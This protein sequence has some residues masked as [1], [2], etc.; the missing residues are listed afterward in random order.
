MMIVT[1]FNHPG[2]II[3]GVRLNESEDNTELYEK[4]NSLAKKLDPSRATTG[5]RFFSGSELKEDIYAI[6]DFCHKGP[7][8]EAV[9][10]N[11]R[12]VTGLN[13][14]VPYIVS[15]FCGHVFPCK[16]WDNENIRE[17]HA[18]MHAR[19][20]S[21]CAVTDNI[22][23]ALGWCAFDYATHGDYG[24]GDK[25]CYHGVMDMFRMPKFAAQFYRS[26]KDP[27]QEIVLE[28]TSVFS[29]GEK[30]DNH[31]APVIIMT[32]C[33]YIKFE[34]YGKA[35]GTF[36]P[37]GNYPG[38]PHP[39]IEIDT[40]D[41]FWIEKWQG[42]LIRGFLKDR[43]VICRRFVRDAYLAE[44]EV[45]PDD[46][47]LFSTYADDTRISC[48]FLDQEGNL[49]PYYPG[50]LKVEHQGDIEIRGPSV[51]AVQGSMAA[52]WIRSTAAGRSGTAEVT[53][54]ALNTTLSPKKLSFKLRAL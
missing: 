8:R 15:E 18:R 19:V 7:K 16:T 4:T 20:Q 14:D 52:F 1:D 47:E 27:S 38:L 3:W 48:R 40:H 24:S 50:V 28:T 46:T 41:S 32:N 44:L 22:M 25:I 35:Q 12:A 51:F 42:A 21:R 23:G 31:V 36:W 54:T 30:G 29:R 39:P 13:Y 11:Q 17:E 43:E 34:I 2:I 9:L 26:Q 53:V 5:V 6:N 49:L 33:D 45:L 37:S 10:Q